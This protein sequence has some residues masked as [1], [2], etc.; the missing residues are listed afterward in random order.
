[1]AEQHGDAA[2]A[3]QAVVRAVN[4]ER[5]L[6]KLAKTTSFFDPSVRT[7]RT[8][9]RDQYVTVL[10]NDY[11][12]A[13]A[14]DVEACMWKSVFYK[15]IEEFRKRIRKAQE[16]GAS[17]IE[18]L[19]KATKTLQS[20]LTECIAFYKLLVMRLQAV[21]MSV[22]IELQLPA[23]HASPPRS[24]GTSK[25][26]DASGSVARSLLFLGDLTRY[27]I[28]YSSS[29][30]VSK[31]TSENDW[32]PAAEFYMQAAQ[33]N[34][35]NGQPHN[36]LAVLAT[37]TEDELGA[38]YHYA[39]A[40]A[41][42]TPFLTAR[43]NLV[44]LFEKSRQ[45]AALLDKCATPNG[46]G[47]GGGRRASGARG[48][49]AAK[50][51]P[52]PHV[53]MA[54]R[55]VRIVGIL[56]T[57][58]SLETLSGVAE[59]AASDLSVA[60][61]RGVKAPAQA[62]S[63]LSDQLL[64]LSAVLVFSLY[65][66]QWVPEGHSPGYSEM[67]QRTVLQRSG[68]TVMFT[69]MARLIHAL[70]PEGGAD[71][72]QQQQKD[73]SSSHPVLP[74]LCIGLQWLASHP[75]HALPDDPDAGELSA[76]AAFFTAA[77]QL[78]QQLGSPPSA[79]PSAA[80]PEDCSLRGFLPMSAAHEHV[81]EW[82]GNPPN[83]GHLRVARVAANLLKT[84]EHVTGFGEGSLQK[85]SWRSVSST[86]EWKHLKQAVAGFRVAAAGEADRGEE[87]VEATEPV[88][89][90]GSPTMDPMEEDELEEEEEVILFKPVQ[91]D[92][93]G[94]KASVQVGSEVVADAPRPPPPRPRHTAAAPVSSPLLNPWGTAA[95]QRQGGSSLQQQQTQQQYALPWMQGIQIGFG[96]SATD[97]PSDGNGTEASPVNKFLAN[98][99][100]SIAD[101]IQNMGNSLVADLGLESS[102]RDPIAPPPSK[103]PSR[104]QLFGGGL[105]SSH[106]S[107]AFAISSAPAPPAVS[108]ANG[109]GT[110]FSTAASTFGNAS[111][112]APPAV[113]SSFADLAQTDPNDLGDGYGW[114]EA[115]EARASGVT[116]QESVMSYAPDGQHY[117]ANGAGYQRGYP[118]P[119][120]P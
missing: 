56:F 41:V 87:Q 20:F 39:R 77:A 68:M 70:L 6:H 13:K 78:L 28:M 35:Y 57:K 102:Q 9:L 14:K 107:P 89:S 119:Y 34:M 79:P 26:I 40:L 117:Q 49:V 55:Y 120:V 32:T 83:C 67:V 84:A 85:A 74:A 103:L 27:K 5:E 76:R 15:P 95:M 81:T 73:V 116:P 53:A 61:A 8:Q 18:L 36:Q 118:N 111:A 43:D 37:Y 25:Q 44:L 2:V 98:G 31:N 112:V 48:S 88:A 10:I 7:I 29:D 46:G 114:L 4:L 63:R 94:G 30:G 59:A 47:R 105:F 86:K 97:L 65:N 45:R 21:Y 106:P 12:L 52:P 64:K 51:A 109:I 38:V 23:G 54:T 50:G 16:S 62:R 104:G 110:F 3:K 96:G 69:F 113:P 75:S 92:K 80:L 58:T 24:H 71:G 93:A 42:K 108:Q 66:A 101:H 115:L 82:A 99:S 72:N 90:R 22:G 100:S 33:I 17:A 60:L 11:A 1:M 91:K 19:Q